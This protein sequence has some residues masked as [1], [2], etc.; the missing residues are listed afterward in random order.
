ML[1]PLTRIQN[2][3]MLIT[4]DCDTRLI[5]STEGLRGNGKRLIESPKTLPN[6]E[7]HKDNRSMTKGQY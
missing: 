1:S 4:N 2:M 6:P 3:Y 7:D 5:E